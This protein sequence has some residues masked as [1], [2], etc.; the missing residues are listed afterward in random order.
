M[1]LGTWSEIVDDHRSAVAEFVA[2]AETVSN[3]SWTV[4]RAPG[5]W[6]P[7]EESEHLVRAYRGLER[8]LLGSDETRQLLPNWKAR[9]LRWIIV[10]RI[11]RRGRFPVG[12]K[13]PRPTRPEGNLGDR[14]ELLSQLVAHAKGFEAAILQ[15]RADN[16]GGTIV[17]PYFGPLPYPT[18]LKLKAEHTRNH[19]GHLP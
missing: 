14:G 6:T 12:A 11:L 4:P 5:K 16:P 2:R 18:F 15:A 3:E 19:T 13:A 7:A 1:N 9:L 17:H 8:S 10:P